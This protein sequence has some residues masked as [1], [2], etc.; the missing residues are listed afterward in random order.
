[1]ILEWCLQNR[2]NLIL[3]I[4]ILRGN[5]MAADASRSKIGRHSSLVESMHKRLP[6]VDS[7]YVCDERA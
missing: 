2:F 3:Q 7:L 6:H 4:D 1:M 5:P